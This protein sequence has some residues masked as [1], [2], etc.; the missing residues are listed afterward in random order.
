MRMIRK[1]FYALNARL[2]KKFL[3][4]EALIKAKYSLPWHFVVYELP[5]VKLLSLLYSV[6]GKFLV[7]LHFCDIPANMKTIIVSF[8]DTTRIM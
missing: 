5:T 3:T 2:K 6:A 7:F 4:M 1:T 8:Q